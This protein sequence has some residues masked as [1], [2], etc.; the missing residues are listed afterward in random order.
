MRLGASDNARKA[1]GT[2]RT[3]VDDVGPQVEREEE[4]AAWALE[5]AWPLPSMNGGPYTLFFCDETSPK[6]S[7][8]LLV[9]RTGGR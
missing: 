2:A 4:L 8:F 9:R 5:R 3:G 6:D 1:A 7:P